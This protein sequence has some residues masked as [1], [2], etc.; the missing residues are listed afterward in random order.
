[1][2][3]FNIPAVMNEKQ[4]PANQIYQGIGVSSGVATGKA[5]ILSTEEDRVKETPIDESAIANEI[6]RF[7]DALIHTR[8]QLH[9]IQREIGDALG[10]E[11][12]SIFD[13]HMLVVDDRSFVE[14]V[15]RGLSQ[16]KINVEAV[17]TDVSERYAQALAKVEDDYLK[18]RAADVRDVARRIIR[19]LAGERSG[20]LSQ[21]EESC[22]VIA[23]D[24]PPS[25]TA[26]MDQSKVIGFATDLG[27]STSHT[28]IMARAMEIP[29]IVGLHDISTR[30]ENGD[31]I[32]MDGQKGVLIVNPT[33]EQ[34]ERYG[35]RAKEQR[36]LRD[37]LEAL[38]DEIA[39]T[40]D[41]YSVILSANIELPADVDA[42]KRHGAFGIGLFR[43]EFLFVSRT[44]LPSEQE[45][46]EVYRD[47][48]EAIHP[49]PLI[50]RTI[51]IGGDKFVNSATAI[52]EVNP[53]L[54]SRAIRFSLAHPAIFMQQLRAILKAS[55][56]ENVKIM[57]PMISRVEEVIEAN[58]LLEK[59]KDELRDEGVSF[60]ESIDV[61][62]M[63]EIPSAALT[64]EHI[65][66][67]VN[68]F[69]I[70]TNDLVQYTLAVDRVNERVAYL[71][72]PTNPAILKL[73]QMTVAASHKCNIWTGVC[74]E[75]AGNPIY[76]PLLI[77]LGA[78]ELSVSPTIV[79]LVKDVIRSLHYAQAEKLAQ[80]CLTCKSG[81]EVEHLCRELISE[82][83]PEILKLIG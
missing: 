4:Q 37:K 34:L 19:N 16:R 43:S 52:Q 18:E 75:M 76:V 31:H 79:P 49:A 74:G 27:S 80:T 82:T 20:S 42:V 62:I 11:N 14:E 7:E 10:H 21:L 36:H 61:G 71:Y 15:I 35:Q 47:V 54:G 60:N 22:I 3:S 73:I 53:F 48:A 46:T 17:I 69:S 33:Q 8:R 38:R 40:K 58:C 70:G 26:G 77:G 6:S 67:H 50:I 2:A 66:P 57:Y 25:E 30:I 12:A 45:Q 83:A 68:F 28:A 56:F 65:A 39:E 81:S 41:G 1:M 23:G 44:E 64:A 51:D 72:E 32:L 9:Q 59:A 78:D 29:A 24:I 5:F 13:A 55:E 63:V